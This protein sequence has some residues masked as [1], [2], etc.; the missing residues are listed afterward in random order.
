VC[1]YLTGFGMAEAKVQSWTHVIAYVG[2]VSMTMYVIFDL[3][4]P[5]MGLIRVDDN[6]LQS[7]IQT[8][9]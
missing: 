6:A 9:K 4:F 5:S 8:M 1:A 3:E 7:L 2:I